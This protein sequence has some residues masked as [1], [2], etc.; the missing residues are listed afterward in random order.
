MDA[1]GQDAAGEELRRT[2]AFSGALTTEDTE[3]HRETHSGVYPLPLR[4]SGTNELARFPSK[5]Y[6]FAGLTRKILE[7]KLLT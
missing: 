3:G 1:A 2:L 6:G 4:I 7:I 5:I